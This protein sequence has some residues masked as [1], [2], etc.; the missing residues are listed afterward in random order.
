M[1]TKNEKIVLNTKKML[2]FEKINDIL[3]LKMLA[4]DAGEC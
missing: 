2:T 4:H 3:P 1:N